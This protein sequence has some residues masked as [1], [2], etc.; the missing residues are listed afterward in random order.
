MSDPLESPQ[1]LLPPPRAFTQGVGTVYQFAGVILFV[2][3]MFICCGSALLS[4]EKAESRDLTTIG[5]HLAGDA[6]DRPAISAQRAIAVAVPT[7]VAMGL[8]VAAIGLG[9][10]A[11]HRGSPYFATAVAGFSLLFWFAETVFAIAV[12]KSIGMALIALLLTVV[13]VGLFMLAIGSW[14]EM[15]RDPPPRGHELLPVDYKIP[16]SHMHQDPP[17]VRLARELEQRRERLAL[18]QKELE[19]LEAK[20]ERT[21]KR[22][23]PS[24]RPDHPEEPA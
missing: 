10:Q 22:S 14:R 1:P 12:V 7:G 13:F 23:I 4:K 20:L 24:K 16:Y 17:E 2:G 8:A 21:L 5:W 9:L 11:Q 15:R 3:M 18:Q 19:M 6:P